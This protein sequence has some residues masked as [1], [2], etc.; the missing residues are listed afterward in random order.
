[1]AFGAVNAEERLTM[2]FGIATARIILLR[3]AGQNAYG[4]DGRENANPEADAH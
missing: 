1:M 3:A 4:K 2:Q